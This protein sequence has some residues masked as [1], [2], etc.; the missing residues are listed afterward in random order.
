MT[1]EK[2]QA[3]ATLYKAG[4]Y[5]DDICKEYGIHKNELYAILAKHDV[6][7]KQVKGSYI[8][9][10]NSCK[11]CGEVIGLKEAKFCPHCGRYIMTEREMCLNILKGFKTKE[12]YMPK[13][14]REKFLADLE[15]CISY[16]IKEGV[17]DEH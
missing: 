9:K 1:P 8:K 4:R 17:K 3:V 6:P 14:E 13:I 15:M 10:K 16:L 2:E 7:R 11:N 5:N 12:S